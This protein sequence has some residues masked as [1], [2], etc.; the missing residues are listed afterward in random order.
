[1]A[2]DLRGDALAHLALGLRIDRQGKIRMGLDV[3]EAGRDGEA[4]RVD[5]LVRGAGHAPDGGYA[6][7]IDSEIARG[8][9]MSCILNRSFRGRAK[10]GARNP[11]SQRRGYGFRTCRFA[12]IR[13]DGYCFI[14]STIAGPGLLLHIADSISALRVMETVPPGQVAETS[15][16]PGLQV[17][18]HW[19]PAPQS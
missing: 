4:G 11:Y 10:R 19:L 1:M 6:I 5:G 12:T 2:D 9:R 7:A 18:S 17:R 15:F 3:D 14:Q 16:S 8:A 13:N